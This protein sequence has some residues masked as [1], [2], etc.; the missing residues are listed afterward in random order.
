MNIF[1]LFFILYSFKLSYG[2]NV[3][4]GLNK[5]DLWNHDNDVLIFVVDKNSYS[6]TDNCKNNFL[7]LGEETTD[8][9]NDSIGTAGKKFSL[10][11]TK[12]K[13]K[14][15]VWVCTVMVIVAISWSIKKP[16]SL[17]LI[18]KMSTS[19]LSFVEE[20]FLGNIID[21]KEVPFKGNAY[22]FSFDYKAIDKPDILKI[23]K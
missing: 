1:G 14:K 23:Y 10:N 7:V 11:S 9:I 22:H 3:W 17:R 16:I 15:N 19:L 13:K 4:I 21:S 6:Q 5:T 20:T 8:D 2:L 12:A 18:K